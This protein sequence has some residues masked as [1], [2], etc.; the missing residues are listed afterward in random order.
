MARDI[1]TIVEDAVCYLWL[2]LLMPATVGG[3]SIIKNQGGEMKRLLVVGG[4]LIIGLLVNIEAVYADSKAQGPEQIV[5]QAKIDH[6]KVSKPAYFPHKTHQNNDCAI[7]H[8]SK[9][10]DG[11]KQVYSKGQKIEKCEVCH[12]SK[13]GMAEGLA[14]FKNAS[15]KLCL[16]CHLENDT[17]LAKCGTCHT[18]KTK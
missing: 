10:Q 17:E 7:C 15:H 2:G 16:G 4:M 1:I 12:N 8:H 6:E 18:K 11:K 3:L 13:S 9:T 14:S 5:L